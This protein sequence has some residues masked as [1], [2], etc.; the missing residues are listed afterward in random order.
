MLRKCLFSVPHLWR[1]CGTVLLET[2]ERRE[3]LFGNGVKMWIIVSYPLIAKA[4]IKPNHRIE[5]HWIIKYYQMINK[6]K[7]YLL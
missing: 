1:I 6:L 2:F 5:I 7:L 3:R 4:E